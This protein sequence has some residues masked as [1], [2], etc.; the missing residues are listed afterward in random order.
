MNYQKQKQEIEDEVNVIGKI[1][2]VYNSSENI[3]IYD[4]AKE[5]FKLNRA[6]RRN[7]DKETLSKTIIV[8][9]G[10][11]IKIIP[12]IIYKQLF[13]YKYRKTN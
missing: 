2:K 11:L 13:D 9:Q 5:I 4:L 1:D 7:L 3:E 10:P 6:I 12:L 8:E